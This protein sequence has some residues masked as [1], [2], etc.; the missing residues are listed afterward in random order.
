[1]KLSKHIAELEGDHIRFVWESPDI[2]ADLSADNVWVLYGRKGSGKSTLLDHLQ[3]DRTESVA[4]IRSRQTDLFTKIISAINKSNDDDRIIEA[5]IASISDFL[6]TTSAMKS[7]VDS[8]RGRMANSDLEVMYNFLVD[9]DLYTGSV[10]RK[11]IKLIS[12]GTKGIKL[13]PNI[14]ELVTVHGV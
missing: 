3:I 14:D 10:L 1:M 6:F 7:I 11:A 2:Y 4:V 8:N 5:S 12:H 9:S 13:I